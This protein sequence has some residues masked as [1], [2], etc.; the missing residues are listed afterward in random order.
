MFKGLLLIFHTLEIS[1]KP[2]GRLTKQREL[3]GKWNK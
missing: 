2:Q 3:F 1:Q